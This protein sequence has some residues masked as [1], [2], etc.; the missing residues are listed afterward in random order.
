MGNMQ[1]VQWD[2]RGVREGGRPRDPRAHVADDVEWEAW[3]RRHRP[4]CG[5]ALARRAV[6]ARRVSA[7]FFEAV[8]ANLEFH[9]FE[10]RN[11]LEG[12]NQV[13]ATIRFDATAKQTGERFQDEEIHLWTFDDD[14][15][16]D[17]ACATTSTPRSTSGSRRGRSPRA[18]CVAVM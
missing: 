17:A 5:R 8:A 4:G 11:L 7:E 14:G 18:G 9:S 12:G 10:P 6:R 15:K 13:A 1:T 3:E 2:L 16:V